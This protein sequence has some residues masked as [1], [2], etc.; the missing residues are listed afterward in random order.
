VVIRRKKHKSCQGEEL[1]VPD[2]WIGA[3]LASDSGLIVTARV[4][5]HTDALIAE[6]V[7]STTDKTD[8]LNWNTDGWGGYQRVLGEEINHQ[9]GKKNTQRLERTN[10]MIRQQ[11]GRW[12]RRQNKFAK[13]WQ[14][15]KVIVRLVI[16]YFN[17]IW[18]HSRLKT[19]AAQRAG[20]TDERWTWNDL[21]TY[22]TVL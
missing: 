3:S 6:L 11:T 17:W 1:E 12:H 22:P 9:I 21:A 18:V 15:T 16:S 7:N 10:G 13:I 20:L 4:G 2:C 5:K 19:T 14:Q 8:C